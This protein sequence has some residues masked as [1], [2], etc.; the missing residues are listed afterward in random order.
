MKLSELP[1]GKRARIRKIVTTDDAI[2]N[3]L[4]SLGIVKGEGIE[5]LKFT[6]AKGTYEVIA[7]DSRVALRRTHLKNPHDR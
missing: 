3:R 7:G 1:I 6:L 2:K 4:Q 5:M